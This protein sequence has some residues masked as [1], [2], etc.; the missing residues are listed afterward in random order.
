M[1]APTSSADER[2]LRDLFLLEAGTA[3]LNHG[4]FGATPRAVFERWQERQ[5][6]MEA[7]P[8]R[9][10]QRVFPVELSTARQSVATLL[11]ARVDDVVFVP[12]ATYACNVIA[13]SLPFGAGDEVLTVH[14]EYGA[15]VQAL[16]FHGGQRGYS[17]RKAPIWRPG[18]GSSLSGT[19]SWCD[20]LL[21]EVRPVTR[22]IFISHITS[23]T[24][25]VLPIA[26]LTRRARAL[27]LKV[28]IDGAHA[29]G[30]LDVDV[31]AID[32]D[33]WFG[34]A[35]K[36]LCSP[37]TTAVLHLAER[38]QHHVQ[39]VIAGWGWGP[40]RKQWVGT[41]YQ[42]LHAWLGTLD[43]ASWLTVP[44]AIAFQQ[45]HDWATVRSRCHAL[46]AE[47]LVT[48]SAIMDLPP[49]VEPG[50][51]E[52]AQMVCIPIRSEL[53][54]EGL[55]ERLFA[56]K[57]EAPVKRHLEFQFVRVSV[58]GYNSRDDLQRLLDVLAEVR[59]GAVL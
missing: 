18:L 44:D 26:E 10:F 12:N 20:T 54:G 21:G 41:P 1:S 30:Q 40:E 50:S 19:A 27:G 25:R 33:A 15:C 32:A 11:N 55:Q 42:D 5:R 22:A 13:A 17:V 58:Q 51:A 2:C 38:F 7:N 28:F 36:W 35:H 8:T 59:A 9:W 16:E 4:A 31:A 57:I 48:G 56:A 46:A 6:A 37:K 29:I 23:P 43:Y 53:D 24:A 45:R 34:N 14:E 39:P 3:Y 47:A 52:H 49:P